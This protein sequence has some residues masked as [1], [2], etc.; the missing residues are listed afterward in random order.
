MAWKVPAVTDLAHAEAAE[1]G[2]ELARRLAGE[3]DREHVARIDQALARLPRD[4]AGEHAGLA[5]AGAGEDRE[6]RG[7]AGDRVALRGVETVEERVHVGTVPPGY[8]TRRATRPTSRRNSRRP[9]VVSAASQL[10]SP[11]GRSCRPPPTPRSRVA[12]GAQASAA[13][14]GF[15]TSRGWSRSVRSPHRIL[16]SVFRSAS[17]TAR[18]FRHRTGCSPA[19]A[20]Y[21]RARHDCKRKMFQWN[22]ALST[23]RSDRWSPSH[24]SASRRWS[25]TRSTRSRRARRR[26]GQRRGGRRGLADAGAAGAAA[27][28]A[29]CSGSTKA[30]RSPQRGPLSY[31][32]VAPDRITDLPRPVCR[33]LAR[34]DADLAAQVRVTV[35]HEVGH[36]FGMSDERLG[37]LGWA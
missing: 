15:L 36:Y 37:E 22:L 30:C 10:G 11:R 2:A 33:E 17:P 28:A 21:G 3:R 25:P 23:V 32:G 35:L 9:R 4:A 1:A 14:S 5:R 8:D 6:R 13:V 27:P 34:D 7:A 31:S 12:P 19:F 18:R 24:S 16:P 29:R 26:D 20:S